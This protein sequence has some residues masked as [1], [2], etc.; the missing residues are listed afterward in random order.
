MSSSSSNELPIQNYRLYWND[1]LIMKQ[2]DS[3]KFIIPRIGLDQDGTYTC[4]PETGMGLGRNKT[5]RLYVKGEKMRF[6][7]IILIKKHSF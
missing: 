2:S 7:S 4:V 1:M 5:L 3:G 6:I